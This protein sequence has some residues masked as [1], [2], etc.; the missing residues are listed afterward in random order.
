MIF[1]RHDAEAARL[2]FVQR[3]VGHGCGIAA[4]FTPADLFFNENGPS[5]GQYL[6]LGHATK[7][8]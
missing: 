3:A 1:E 4:H 5:V 8:F 2:K 7:W 6:P